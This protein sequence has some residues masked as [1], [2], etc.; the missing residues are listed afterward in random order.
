MD[1]LYICTCTCTCMWTGV[2]FDAW[3]TCWQCMLVLVTV[4]WVTWFFCVCV[5][6]WG[7]VFVCIQCAI[8]CAC[9]VFCECMYV[10]VC[11]EVGVLYTSLWKRPNNYF[12]FFFAIYGCVWDPANFW[13]YRNCV[14]SAGRHVPT[15]LVL[16]RWTV[17]ALIHSGTLP[18]PEALDIPFSLIG[19][20][21]ALMPWSCA[22]FRTAVSLLFQQIPEI[23]GCLFQM[24]SLINRVSWNNI[25]NQ[26]LASSPGPFM[27]CLAYSQ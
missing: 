27:R 6:M 12:I 7:V 25:Q 16:S 9:L 17:S 4:T 26:Q 24:E 5:Y 14:L 20:V 21:N 1:I 13:L 23:W 22:I 8:V 3:C 2:Q 11:M 18:T 19:W 15:L 10:I